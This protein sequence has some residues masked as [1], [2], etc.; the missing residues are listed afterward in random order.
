VA[1]G[2]GAALALAPRKETLMTAE[3]D[4][5]GIVGKVLVDIED[6]KG[7][8][9]RTIAEQKNDIAAGAGDFEFRPLTEEEKEEF[10]N[11]LNDE[12]KRI[13]AELGPRRN[14]HALRRDSWAK[15]L[16]HPRG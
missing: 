2:G 6:I 13:L 9:P 7:Q 8:F 10:L 15:P 3:D 12:G 4:L 11:S 5:L 1:G 14:S 16:V